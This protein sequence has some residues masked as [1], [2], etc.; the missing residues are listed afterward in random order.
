MPRK[1]AKIK[2]FLLGGLN[3]IGKNMTVLEYKNDIVVIDCGL[4]FPEDEM[5]GIDIVIPDVSY[6]VKNKD[7]IKALLI[8]HGHEDHIGAIPFFLKKMNVP[9]YTMPFTMGLIALKLK[10]NNISGVEL[11]VIQP[12][13]KIVLGSFTAEFIRVN[14]S[15]PDSCAI[16]LYTDAGTVFHT[17]DFKVDYTPVDDVR[18]DLNKIAEIGSKGVTLMLGESTNVERPGY[19][20]SEASVGNTLNQIFASVDNNRI[21][22]AT[23]AS[24]VHRLQQ[25]I[26]AAHKTGKKVA[27]SG[28][29]MANIMDVASE[30][31]Y[32]KIPDNTYIDLR[33]INKYDDNELVIITTGSQ[34]E[35][36]SAL[37]R[38]SKMEH[39][40]IEIRRGD[41]VVFSA[42]PIP[43]NEKLVSRVIN[44]LF[45]IGATVIYDS[46]SEIH[47]SGHARQEELKLML[48]L[49]QPKFFIPIHGEKRHLIQ[50]KEMS[51]KIG[52]KEENVFLLSNGDVLEVDKN[53]AKVTGKVP[54]GNILVDGL[55]VGD[56]GNIVLRDRKHLSE[57][58]LIVVVI[59]LKESDKIADKI[60]IIS[61]GFIYVKESEELIDDIKAVV[62]ESIEG[63]ERRDMSQFN[64]I[65]NVIR[66]NL[67][68]F[69]LEKT[70]RNPMI[71]P[72][73][74]D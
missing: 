13:Q 37:T 18:I 70:G 21:F 67:K 8:T 25:I 1:S 17:G 60:E 71:L 66:D 42:H 46:V 74:L 34:G 27:V 7:R 23:F 12:N 40:Q 54:S 4:I 31:N 39:R 11:N 28:R 68:A 19:T 55:G 56:I 62:V 41:V 30:L 65:K 72:I 3:E 64:Y 47:V 26:D 63:F 50:H 59:P 14:H 15:I 73:V 9:I 20:E 38:M 35:P 58:G 29:S 53:E 45:A 10:E 2:A 24:N 32:L 33:D 69:L 48:S 16:A 5:L 61:R 52:L 43:G 22:V 57:D 51:I 36:L 49:V 44:D 6:L